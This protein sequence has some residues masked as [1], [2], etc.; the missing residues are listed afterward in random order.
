MTARVFR[1]Q[2]A[3]AMGLIT[4]VFPDATALQAAAMNCAVAIAAKSPLA[5]TGTKRVLLHSRSVPNIHD[6]SRIAI[7]LVNEI[8]RDQCYLRSRNKMSVVM[9]GTS[10]VLLHMRHA[11]PS[12]LN[13][14][15]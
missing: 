12:W 11:P 3:K 13:T 1:A 2:E 9:T 15:A 10:I 5:V 7:F 8:C 4:E 6:V 14:P